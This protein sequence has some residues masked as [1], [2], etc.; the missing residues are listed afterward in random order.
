MSTDRNLFKNAGEGVRK[1]IR[2]T[3]P[4]MDPHYD[5]D[6]AVATGNP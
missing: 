3:A 6:G 5:S 2:I 1:P 4:A